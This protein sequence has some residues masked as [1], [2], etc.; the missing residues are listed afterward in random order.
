MTKRESPDQRAKRQA[1][2][3]LGNIS[4]ASIDQLAC[5]YEALGIVQFVWNGARKQPRCAFEGDDDRVP[6]LCDEE[7]GRIFRMQGMVALEAYR[8]AP[9]GSKFDEERRLAI[10]ADW[11]C[12]TDDTAL[13]QEAR[14]A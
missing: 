4:K 10:I 14:A 8:H 11:T 1:R 9:C 13:E 5:L 2:E 7:L 6:D 12:K 3:A